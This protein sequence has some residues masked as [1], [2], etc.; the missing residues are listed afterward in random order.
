[1]AFSNLIDLNLIQS[2]RYAFDTATSSISQAS[3]FP[4]AGTGTSGFIANEQA[5]NLVATGLRPGTF[6]RAYLNGVD[7]TQYC[8]Q[9]GRNLGDGLVSTASPTISSFVNVDSTIAPGGFIYFTFYYTAEVIAS[10]PVEQAGAAASLIAGQRILKIVSSDGTSTAELAF[11]PPVFAKNEP[12]VRVQKIPSTTG[13]GSQVNYITETKANVT[14]QFFTVS[15]YS[16]IQT[17]YAD[18]EIISKSG[19]VFLTSLDLFFKSKPNLLNNVTGNPAP[20]VSIC[21]CEVENNEPVLSRS[22]SKSLVYRSYDQIFSYSDAS[23]ATVFGFVEPIRLVTG[24]FYGIVVTFEDPAYAL[25]TNKIGNNLVGTNTPSVGV[26]SNKDGKLFLKNNSNIFNALADSELKFN[27]KCAKFSS[28]SEIKKFI[29]DNY[30]FLTISDR[31]G[32]FIGGESVYKQRATEAGTISISRGSNVILG[33][34]TDFTTLSEDEAIVIYNGDGAGG[35]HVAIVD[36][37]ANANY[38]TTTNIL[39]YSN[40]AAAYMRTV[41]GKVYY[42]DISANQLYL[43]GSTAGSYTFVANDTIIGTLSGAVANVYSVDNISVDRVRAKTDVRVPSSTELKFD[44]RG[45][46]FTGS[47]YAYNNN[48]VNSVVPNAI[49][50]TEIT[51]YDAYILS[52]SNELGLTTLYSN[53]ELGVSNKSVLLEAQLRSFANPYQSPIV[54]NSLINLFAINNLLS[55]TVTSAATDSVGNAITIDSEVLGNGTSLSRHIG[56][57]ITFEDGR[58]AEDVRVYM[59]AYRPLNTDIKVYVKLHNSS[60]TEAFDDKVWTPLEYISGTDAKY[61][62]SEDTKNFIEYEL[63]L[64]AYTESAN[65]LPI[66][67]NVVYGSNAIQVTDSTRLNPS[68]YVAAG[69]VIRIYD[70]IFPTTNYI[71]VPVTSANATHIILSEAIAS[72]NVVGTSFV[73]K[74]KYPSAAFN[75]PENDNISRYYNNQRAAYDT[76]NTMQVKIVFTG[77]FTYRSPK[78]DQLQV[79]GVSA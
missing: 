46:A 39:P 50:T 71:I 33:S 35:S 25:W 45:T 34:F 77:D 73:D 60:D 67:F 51:N 29:S 49:T 57:K 5:F 43:N 30:E 24:K 42:Q 48:N 68:A 1:M 19:I 11:S 65:N 62:S 52:R 15:N 4:V 54:E 72:N 10:T 64:R 58:R 75:N 53:T 76:F 13:I 32:N 26:N 16:L 14:D 6:H 9:L 8:K 2:L 61:S 70:A 7:V 22:Y 23:T 78:V 40:T 74:L 27:V 18:P 21:I 37:I 12:E 59:T 56:K 31:V 20:G 44:L 41:V 66:S 3:V 28:N 63:G 47:T 69:D 55:T 36:Q 17:F 38:M 79:I